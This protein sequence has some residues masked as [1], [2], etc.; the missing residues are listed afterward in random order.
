MLTKVEFIR[1]LH[2]AFAIAMVTIHKDITKNPIPYQKFLNAVAFIGMTAKSMEEVEDRLNEITFYLRPVSNVVM[3]KI[4]WKTRL[5]FK[6]NDKEVDTEE[7]V[8]EASTEDSD[9]LSEEAEIPK[10][11]AKPKAKRKSRAKPKKDS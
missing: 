8:V 5:T 9:N 10:P 2:A 6:E 1:A 7:K 4:I 3:A 11:K